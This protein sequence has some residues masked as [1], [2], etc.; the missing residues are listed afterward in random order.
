M[1][2]GEDVVE[3]TPVISLTPTQRLI[4]K[5]IIEPLSHGRGH[6][7]SYETVVHRTHYAMR[8]VREAV[9]AMDVTFVAS[10]LAFPGDG[11]ALDRVAYVL[12]RHRRIL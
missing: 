6:R 3:T 1:S 7:S 5:A 11:D 4:G 9:A 12:E 2:P 8:T 10:G